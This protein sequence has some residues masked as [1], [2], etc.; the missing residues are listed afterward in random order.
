MNIN[1]KKLLRRRNTKLMVVTDDIAE[2]IREI[3][4][5]LDTSSIDVLASA[6]ELLKLSLNKE[7]I[8][9]ED[10]NQLKISLFKSKTSK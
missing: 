2:Q 7:I 10:N 3:S 9:K 1:I 6:L 4:K 8:I 5:D